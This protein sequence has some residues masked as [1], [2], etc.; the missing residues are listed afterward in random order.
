MYEEIVYVL[1]KECKRRQES[2]KDD[3]G[4]FRQ[5]TVTRGACLFQLT[6]NNSKR[7]G[8]DRLRL[9]MYLR[10]AVTIH[11]SAVPGCRVSILPDSEKVARTPS[12]WLGGSDLDDWARKG[13]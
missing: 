9:T 6:S 2:L 7:L 11:R 4:A 3:C 5:T 1:T 8:Y 12:V 10:Q 13:L